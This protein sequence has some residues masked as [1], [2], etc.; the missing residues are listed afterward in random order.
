MTISNRLTF[1]ISAI[2]G[3]LLIAFA[4]SVY[5]AYANNRE[6]EYFNQI[7][8]QAE[9]KV[10]LLLEARVEAATLQLIYQN[11]RNALNQ[12]E[13]AIY[14]NEFDLLYHD[15]VDNDIVKETPEMLSTIQDNA[16]IRFKQGMYQ[17]VGFS[18]IHNGQQYIV[19][20]AAY[21]IYGYAKLRNLLYILVLA[22]LLSMVIVFFSA[23]FISRQ[24]LQPI[25]GVVDR[26]EAITANNLNLRLTEGNRKDE[27]ATLA[28]TFNKMLDRLEQS[29]DGQ[30][31]FVSNIAHEI[32]TP[33]AA[34][35]AELEL[36][37]NK[38]RN[39]ATYRNAIEN[40][41]DDAQKLSK[42]SSNML[43]L[44]KASYDASEIKLKPIRVDELLMAAKEQFLRGNDACQ[45]HL[46]FKSEIEDEKYLMTLGNEYL[47]TTAFKN[48]MENSC[49]FSDNQTSYIV[50][51]VTPTALLLYFNDEGIGINEADKD[52]IFTPFFRGD[53]QAYSKGAGIGLSLTIKIIELHKGA[54]TLEP[55]AKGSSFLIRLKNMVQA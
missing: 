32:R 16:E 13:V 17:I 24:A 43:D 35:M 47:L 34:I 25:T 3:V 36:T 29:F 52:L 49:K 45:V 46:D 26:V 20:A 4:L 10:S 15:E 28:I 51:D 21:D 2:I 48:L 19:T 6:D 53:N 12:E 5:F 31:Q 42:L 22:Y 14:N 38:E 18:H 50:I 39:I 9:T 8:L 27:I 55:K 40:V 7:R 23:R 44:A 1:I 11:S 30:K 54:L 37:L 33:L 41:L